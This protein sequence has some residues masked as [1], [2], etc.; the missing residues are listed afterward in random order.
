MCARKATTES[1]EKEIF[2]YSSYGVFIRMYH[3][4]KEAKEQ[5]GLKSI[6]P[7]SPRKKTSGSFIWL[8]ERDD[9][10]ALKIADTIN[11]SRIVFKNLPVLQYS[12]DG[13]FIKKYASSG[14]AER[15]NGI[16]RSKV[17]A[18]CR[19]KI[20]TAGGYIWRYDVEHNQ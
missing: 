18:C 5:T 15:V 8:L 9:D 17:G 6:S 4:I 3:S 20:K 7:S 19:G 10:K 2:Q 1:K 13:S 16:A 11:P 12:I 14:E